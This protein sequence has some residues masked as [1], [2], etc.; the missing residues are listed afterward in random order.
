MPWSTPTLKQVRIVVRDQIRGSLPGA[1]ASVPNSVL[2]VLS[3]AQGGLCHLNL[4]YLDWLALQILPDTAETEWLDRHGDIWLVNADGSTGRKAATFAVGN[5]AITGTPGTVVPI[6]SQLVSGLI[7]YETIEA[8]TIGP[9]PTFCDVRALDP[10]IVGNTDVGSIMNF[11]SVIPGVTTVKTGHIT[12]GI[13]EENDDDLRLRVLE[14]I[15]QP[16]M[17]GDAEDYVY[18][19]LGV[20]GVTRAWS[21]PNEQGM[22][23]ITLRFMMDIYRADNDGFPLQE[24]IDAVT[25][26]IDAKRPVAVKDRF[27]VAPIPEPVTFTI[28]NLEPETESIRA[29][30]TKNVTAML[31]LKAAPAH[32]VDG[33]TQPAQTIYA[34][35]VSDAI[36]QTPGVDSFRLVMEDHVMPNNGCLAVLGTIVYD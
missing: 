15:R 5:I 11:A 13:D 32:A 21:S 30:I 29:G 25:L 36:M 7:G 34:A 16:P 4:Q 1:D 9:Q 2:R 26:A 12:G 22:G 24:D 3:D 28:Q 35:W 8:V 19:A 27:I 31:H 17:G 33:V 20:P 6:A 14:R 23:T 10:G 18:W